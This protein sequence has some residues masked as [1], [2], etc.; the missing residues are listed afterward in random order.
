ETIEKLNFPEQEVLLS[1]EE[2]NHRQY[3]AER[4]MKLGNYF[5]DKVKI[6]FEDSEGMKM[7]E[8][9]IWGVIDRRLLLKRGLILP[10]YRVHEIII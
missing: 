8:T 7:V 3:E 2:I 1:Q 9:T 4:A 5:K 6:I 10:L